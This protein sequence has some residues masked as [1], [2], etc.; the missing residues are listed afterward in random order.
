MKAVTADVGTA[1]S[2]RVTRRGFIASA[3][4][5]LLGALIGRKVLEGRSL[6]CVAPGSVVTVPT[7]VD[8][9]SFPGGMIEWD[10]SVGPMWPAVPEGRD[11][12]LIYHAPLECYMTDRRTGVTTRIA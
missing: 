7:D 1:D 4:F 2:T 10:D 12:F 8:F 9:Y 6:G 3:F 11:A 5:L